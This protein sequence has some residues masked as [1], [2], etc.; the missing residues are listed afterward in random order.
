M[1]WLR[2][3]VDY[4]DPPTQSNRASESDSNQGTG[5]SDAKKRLKLVL[6]HDRTQLP[7]SLLEEMREEMIKVISRYVEI[8]NSA[9]E[10]NLEPT[11]DNN[12]NTLALVANIPVLRTIQSSTSAS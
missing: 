10:L 6:M 12:T 8:D 4:I 11:G 7:A 5:A 1:G 3:L 2:K 9:L